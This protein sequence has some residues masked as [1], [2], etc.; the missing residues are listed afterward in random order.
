MS[1]IV[2]FHARSNDKNTVKNMF[3]HV[4]VLNTRNALTGLKEKK[5][6]YDL[7]LCLCKTKSRAGVD[8]IAM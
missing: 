5:E 4:Y 3:L 7:H 1:H 8:Y 6:K 2:Q